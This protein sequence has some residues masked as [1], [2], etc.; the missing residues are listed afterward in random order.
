MAKRRSCFLVRLPIS[1]ISEVVNQIKG[2][3]F[4]RREGEENDDREKKKVSFAPFIIVTYKAA[5]LKLED[6]DR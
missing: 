3:L 1:R 6:C 2:F 5:N 4:P